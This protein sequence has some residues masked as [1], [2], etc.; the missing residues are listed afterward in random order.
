MKSDCARLWRSRIAAAEK[1]PVSARAYCIQNGINPRQFYRWRIQLAQS[2]GA[3]QP[4]E[5]VSV[6][7]A[8]SPAA[9]VNDCITL[10]I[11]GVEIDLRTGFSVDLL[12]TVV[13]AL[14]PETC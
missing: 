12:R 7:V 9:P 1:H 10:K 6:E 8:P 4:A 14:G 11:A 5:W 2:A 3:K 13:T